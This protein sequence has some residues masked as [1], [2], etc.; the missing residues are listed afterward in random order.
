M[1]SSLEV[2]PVKIKMPEQ[3]DLNPILPPHAFLLGIIAPPRSGKTNLIMNLL[4][5]DQFYYNKKKSPYSY[6]DEIFYLSPTQIFDKTCCELLP[7]LEN[8][9]QITDPDELVFADTILDKIT[10]EQAEV[11]KEDRKKILVV[12]LD[13]IRSLLFEK[14]IIEARIDFIATQ[15]LNRHKSEKIPIV[16]VCVLNG[17]FAFYSKL[18]E[19]LSSLDPECD[20]IKV[21][22]Y[23]GRERGDLNM[24]LDKSIDVTNKHVYLIDDI[25]DS[26]ITMN[27]LANH[28]YQFEPASIQI[29]TLI[30]RYINE[31]N[32]PIGS[33]YGFEIT[34]E[35]VV[36]F[37]MDDDLGKK[38]SLP[39]ILAI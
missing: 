4:L 32:M 13:F 30:K 28:F 6:F 5:N 37:G 38:R 11:E 9:I 33:L 19:K 27:A 1:S 39:Y 24:I 8:L 21:R 23:E 36:G 35:W 16:L 2:L 14:E 29:V 7:K 20:F 10:K 12:I 25:Y 18:V 34:D 3:D 31:V 15:I 22:S 17:G 26:G